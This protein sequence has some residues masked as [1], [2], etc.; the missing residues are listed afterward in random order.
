M[1][2]AYLLDL[3][4]TLY[5]DDGPVPGAVD[6]VGR[7]KRARLPYRFVTNTS[8]RPRSSIV[9][10][11]RGYGFDV[12]AQDIFTAV[13]AGAEMAAGSGAHVVAPFITERSLVDLGA[14]ELV[15]G[16]SGRP[17][18]GVRV[19]AVIIGDLGDRWDYSLMQQAFRFLMDGAELIAL[20]RDR[21]WM[22]GDGLAL[23][24]GAFVAGLEFAAGVTARVAGKPSEGF[25]TT[26]VSSLGLEPGP[27][28]RMVGDDLWS[29]VE[30][31]QRAGLA[32][33]LV[34]TGKFREDALRSGGVTPDQVIDSIADLPL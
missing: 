17:A 20:S 31:A 29:D 7:L 24:A 28:V 11:L 5:T 15:G 16:T 26:A 14:F 12:E 1:S 9:E 32:G 34:R 2:T 23:D 4:G 6:T 21:Y 13:L 30:G 27:D 33:W 19:D 18:A 3:A 8:S 22:R 25:F 10:R